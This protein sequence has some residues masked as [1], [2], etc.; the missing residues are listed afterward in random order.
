MADPTPEDLRKVRD[1]LREE[2]R[3]A[4]GMLKD[5]RRE[6]KEAR[7][8][9]PLLTDELFEAEVR[10]QVDAL[11]QA[12]GRQMD[13]SVRK[14]IAEFDKLTDTLMGTDRRSVAAGKASLPELAENY[15]PPPEA[16]GA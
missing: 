7:G 6:M 4:R 8:L 5:L 11:K 13:A 3:E 12:T 9:L 10:K 1:E 16:P 2:I 14:V 15:N